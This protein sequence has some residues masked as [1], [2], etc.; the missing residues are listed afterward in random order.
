VP[1][2]GLVFGLGEGRLVRDRDPAGAEADVEVLDGVDG[3]DRAGRKPGTRLRPVELAIEL[4]LVLVARGGLEP[5]DAD[6]RVV[7]AV[8]AEGRLAVT[9][10]FDLA[11]LGGLDPY[12][13]LGFRDVAQQ[14]TQNQLVNCPS[15]HN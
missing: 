3:A 1:D 11:G 5:L 9:E 8:D 15:L 10:D 13:G 7:V 12:G 14:G 4:D 6:Q 2:L